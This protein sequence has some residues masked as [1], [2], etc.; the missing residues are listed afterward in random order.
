M[1]AVPKFRRHTVSK[2]AAEAL[3]RDNGAAARAAKPADPVVI[4]PVQVVDPGIPARIEA[5]PQPKEKLKA[6]YYA[7]VS[8]LMECQ[9]QS[10]ESQKEHFEELIRSDPGLVFAGAFVDVGLTGTKAE[11]RPELQ[12]LLQDCKDGK[13]QVVMAKSISQDLGSDP[14]KNLLTP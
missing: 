8:T 10:I 2:N 3:R 7:R 11:T 13:V 9:E 12:R 4:S 14:I 5:A 6:A 1:P